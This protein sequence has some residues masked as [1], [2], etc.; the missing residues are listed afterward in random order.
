MRAIA[1]FSVL[2]VGLFF[3]PKAYAAI[4]INEVMPNPVGDE[5]QDEWV[6]LKN[7]GS[8]SV[9]IKNYKLADA[10][11]HTLEINETYTNEGTVINP[12]S[13]IVIYRRG[14]SDFSLNNS[15]SETVSLYDDATSSAT[16]VNQITYS[17]STESK[18]WGRIPDGE[19]DIQNGLEQTP[20]AENKAPQ[21]SPSPAPSPS[22]T[23]TS[24]SSPTPK[25]TSSTASV[26]KS[27][28]PTL[29][30]VAFLDSEPDK[31][32]IALGETLGKSTEASPE[33]TVSGG[34][35]INPRAYVSWLLTGSGLI[36]LTA[37]GIPLLKRHFKTGR[38][39]SDSV[40]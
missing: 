19:G 35:A 30:P 8:D 11:G 6:E 7:T 16:L 5:K 26:K 32:N 1:I 27:P 15:D 36:F 21:T 13:W 3:P 17:G 23:P 12:G 34:L 28:Q 10:S 22:P 9:D 25:P 24:Q 4:V 40:Q 2:L 39:E 31:T 18:T 38:T 20:D 37:A 29:E 14:H 33:A